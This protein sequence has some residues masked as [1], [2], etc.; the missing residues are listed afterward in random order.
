M[1]MVT[2]KTS[3]YQKCIDECNRYAQACIECM[4]LCLNEP[5]VSARINCISTLNECACI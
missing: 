1:V 5:D 4:N 2:A 3:K